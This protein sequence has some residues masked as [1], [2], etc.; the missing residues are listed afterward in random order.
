MNRISGAG[1]FGNFFTGKIN[2]AS[3]IVHDRVFQYCAETDGV[4]Y[5]RFVL[6]CKVDAFGIAAAF[7]IKDAVLSPAML[8]I[9]NQETI[10]VGGQ[11]SFSGSGQTKKQ[12]DFI[13]RPLVCRAV[14]RENTLFRQQIV[15]DGENGFFHFTGILCAADQNDLA[16]KIDDDESFRICSVLC[17]IGGHAGCAEYGESR[18]VW[19][20]PTGIAAT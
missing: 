20:G 15:Q 9:A 6:V 2:G 5:L 3:C 19:K 12:R 8:I 7:K 18:L 17:R 11:R 10:R 4:P 13:V 1:V 16:G 14:H